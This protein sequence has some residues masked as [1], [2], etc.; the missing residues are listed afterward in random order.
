MPH[1]IPLPILPLLPLQPAP[2]ARNPAWPAATIRA[3]PHHQVDG[4]VRNYFEPAPLPP[5][6]L[7]QIFLL[8]PRISH[9]FSSQ[10]RAVLWCG[11]AV[12]A[13]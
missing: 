13:V 9:H 1:D 2:L 5:L 3:A 6:A 12:G 8:F 10:R 11:S 4:T 7:H